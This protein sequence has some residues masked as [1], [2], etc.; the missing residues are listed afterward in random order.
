MAPIRFERCDLCF[1]NCSKYNYVNLKRNKEKLCNLYFC[2]EYCCLRYIYINFLSNY[3][4]YKAESKNREQKPKI[5]NSS[6]ILFLD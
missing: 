2:S 4:H 5:K 6:M 1:V 3:E